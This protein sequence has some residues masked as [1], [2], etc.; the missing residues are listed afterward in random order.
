MWLCCPSAFNPEVGPSVV[1]DAGEP[2]SPRAAAAAISI[3]ICSGLNPILTHTGTNSTAIIGI[4]PNEVPMPIVMNKPKI[5][6]IREVRIIL[7]GK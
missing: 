1:S 6:I 5:S 3:I 2:A 7:C 4:V